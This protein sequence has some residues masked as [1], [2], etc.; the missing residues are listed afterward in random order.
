MGESSAFTF[1]WPVDD[2]GPRSVTVL[3]LP[4]GCAG[5]VVVDDVSL[6]P[7]IGG[8]RMSQDVTAAEV[9]RL[10][11]AMTLKNSAAGLPHGGGKAGIRIPHAL[12]DRDREAVIR[13]FAIGIRNIDEYIPG[14][15]M[16]TDETAM[17]WIRDEIGR[18]VGLP[19][20]LGGIPLDE[21]GATGFGIGVCAEAV[22]TTGRLRLA[23]ARVAIQGFGAVG[24][25]AAVALRQRGAHVVAVADRSATIYDPVGLDVDSLVAFKRAHP[26]DQYPGAETLASGDVLTLDC[27]VLV[28]AAQPD[29]VHEANAAKIQA[30][31]IL[32]GANI[33]V[34]DAA[35]TELAARGVLCVPDFIANAGG[36]ICA[37]VEY[38][39]GSRADAFRAIEERI[40]ANTA[41]LLRRVESTGDSPRAAAQAMA[42]AR[43]RLASTFQ[44]TF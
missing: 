15:D 23:D 44:R 8:V 29:V 30:S 9:A 17:A 21:V 36:V 37:A 20:V 40:S 38:A 2:D 3:R 32:P 24:R 42:R 39:G 19:A 5:V 34:T 35:E 28:P 27:D 33:A 31:V 6:G 25:H 26:L 7:A 11:R 16:G 4:S 10:A 13:A 12:S 41:E 43:I 1:P 14:P 18:A 22:A